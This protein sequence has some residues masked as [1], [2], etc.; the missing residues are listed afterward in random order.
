MTDVLGEQH[1]WCSVAPLSVMSR[2]FRM[3]EASDDDP[4]YVLLFRAAL[5]PDLSK[6]KE[7]AS[8]QRLEVA[9]ALAPDLRI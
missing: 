8:V 5:T 3:M 1:M 7:S 2:L 4:A 6:W 9:T